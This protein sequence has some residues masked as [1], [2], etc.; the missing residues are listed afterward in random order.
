VT[1]IS[2]FSHLMCIISANEGEGGTCAHLL[3]SAR[4]GEFLVVAVGHLSLSLD[5]SQGLLGEG[6]GDGWSPGEDRL[7]GQGEEAA[8][9]EGAGCGEVGGDDGRRGRGWR[10]KVNAARRA[11]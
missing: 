7:K 11:T 6:R 9:V 10:S 2:D 4:G 1:D 5:A 8:M 3:H